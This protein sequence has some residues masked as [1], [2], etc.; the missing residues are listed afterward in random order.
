MISTIAL[1]IGGTFLLAALLMYGTMTGLLPRVF[2]ARKPAGVV[3]VVLLAAVA[4]YYFGPDLS[5]AWR[6]AIAPAAPRPPA[7]PKF[8]ARSAESPK[9]RASA[10]RPAPRAEITILEDPPAPAP[11][12]EP[13]P[14]AAAADASRSAATAAAPL[15]NDSPY[16]SGIK[17]GIKRV[18]R[19]LHIRKEPS[20]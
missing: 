19:L 4:F 8:P 1:E 16:D 11:E 17:R 5:P 20:K 18:G 3:L 7:V 6:A 10:S 12:I 2:H 9:P 13:A 14:E 15:S